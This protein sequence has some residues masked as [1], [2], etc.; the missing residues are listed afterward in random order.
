MGMLDAYT[1]RDLQTLLALLTQL[2]AVGI[3]DI[4]FARA[5]VA[6]HVEQAARAGRRA[7]VQARRRMRARQRHEYPIC[8]S[9]GR[10]RLVPTCKAQEV[11][12]IKRV[13][14][15]ECYYSKIVED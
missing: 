10:G 4:R 5:R 7:A 13:G 6:R 9:C 2:E 1:P 14:C 11:E 8:P 12:G 15:K 3:T